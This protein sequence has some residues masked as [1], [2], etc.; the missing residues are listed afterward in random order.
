MGTAQR[1]KIQKDYNREGS[2][3][4]ACCTY[5]WCAGCANCQNA[6]EIKAAQKAGQFAT[7]T[8]TVIAAPVEQQMTS[9]APAP[10]VEQAV[11]PVAAVDQAAV[12]VDQKVL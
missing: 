3:S 2:C 4:G 12:T 9:A 1:Q 6:R 11:A 10:V 8:G 5:F 7:S